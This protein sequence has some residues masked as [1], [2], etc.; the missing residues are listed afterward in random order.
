MT[1]LGHRFVVSWAASGRRRRL[2]AWTIRL[3]APVL[4]DRPPAREPIFIVGSP[5]SGTTLLFEL[6]R[7]SPGVGALPGESHLLS[8]P[9]HPTARGFE[10]THE[11][12]AEDV[13]PNE[14]RAV[15][16]MIDRIA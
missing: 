3:A 11:L 15:R 13:A 12:R 9:F 8:E 14:P 7:R 1:P 16:W 5:R 6:L 2:A 4:P 10:T